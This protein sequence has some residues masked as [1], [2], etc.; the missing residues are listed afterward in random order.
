MPKSS[1]CS[2]HEYGN[3][4][5]NSVKESVQGTFP[6][7]TASPIGGMRNAFPEIFLKNRFNHTAKICSSN[8]QYNDTHFEERDITPPKITSRLLSGFYFWWNEVARLLFTRRQPL[9]TQN[10]RFSSHLH[11][12]LAC[13]DASLHS[14]CEVVRF[15]LLLVAA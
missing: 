10:R 7:K 12:S 11:Q 13:E 8:K 9:F 1:I 15:A 5:F 4:V 2:F 14:A 6:A 3:V